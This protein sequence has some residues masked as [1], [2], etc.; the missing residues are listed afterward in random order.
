MNKLLSIFLGALMIAG[1]CA[2]LL[3][4]LKA[5]DGGPA[6]Y[7][8]PNCGNCCD[9]RIPGG[10]PDTRPLCCSLQP[11]KIDKTFGDI[12]VQ[13]RTLAQLPLGSPPV[14]PLVTNCERTNTKSTLATSSPVNIR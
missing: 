2:G 1:I 5:G 8:P 11:P 9:V 4:P 3:T 7:C 10:A 12:N 14:S 6:P 13:D